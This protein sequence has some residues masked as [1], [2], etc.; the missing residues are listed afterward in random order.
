MDF[1]EKCFVKIPYLSWGQIK[2]W[3]KSDEISILGTHFPVS[4]GTDPCFYDGVGGGGGREEGVLSVGVSPYEGWER[5]GSY[6]DV[7]WTR[8]AFLLRSV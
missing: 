4:A 7:P 6:A 5:V 8:H 1:S 3:V 2:K